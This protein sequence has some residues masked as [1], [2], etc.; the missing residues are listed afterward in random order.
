MQPSSAGHDPPP[1]RGMPP[2]SVAESVPVR[3]THA[4]LLPSR[5]AGGRPPGRGGRAPRHAALGNDCQG[6]PRADRQGMQPQVRRTWQ[7]A[8]AGSARSNRRTAAAPADW[9]NTAAH[10]VKPWPR[11]ALVR[12]HATAGGAPAGL[13]G[14]VR[15]PNP[16]SAAAPAFLAPLQPAR[17][18]RRCRT[19]PYSPTLGGACTC[20][21]ALSRRAPSPSTTGRWRSWQRCGALRGPRARGDAQLTC[22]ACPEGEHAISGLLSLPASLPRTI[23]PAPAA[24]CAPRP[25]ATSGTSGR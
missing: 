22:G 1:A 2:N 7:R 19:P 5:T 8:P 13:L 25:S 16:A 14:C 12:A 20:H 3:E 9:R 18:R 21:L 11:S 6:P 4:R 10:P 23:S 15:P 24:Y 17:S